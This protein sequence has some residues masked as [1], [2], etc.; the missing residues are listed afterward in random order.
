[1]HLI[2]SFFL[3]SLRSFFFTIDFIVSQTY[4]LLHVFGLVDDK[5]NQVTVESA[6]VVHIFSD[7]VSASKLVTGLTSLSVDLQVEP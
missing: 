1:M 6:K 5:L 3:S 7:D 2:N 4:R